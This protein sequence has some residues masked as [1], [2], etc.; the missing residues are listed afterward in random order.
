MQADTTGNAYKPTA[1]QL[2]QEHRLSLLEAG[3]ADAVRS[4]QAIWEKL[5]RIAAGIEELKLH[6][7][8]NS[9]MASNVETLRADVDKLNEYVTAQKGGW[10]AITVIAII[11]TTLCGAAATIGGWVA[12]QWRQP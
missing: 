4:R 5:D 10:K 11:T 3:H 7:A 8:A 6:N 1:M 2:D 12:S 9:A